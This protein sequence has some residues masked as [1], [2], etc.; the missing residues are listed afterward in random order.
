[1]AVLRIKYM[2]KQTC[3]AVINS[4]LI[5]QQNRHGILLGLSF[6]PG[7]FMGFAGRPRDFFGS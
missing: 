6:G 1:M 7:T 2:Y 5:R 3:F 4:L